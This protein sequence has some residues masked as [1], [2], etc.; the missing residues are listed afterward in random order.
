MISF[1]SQE[2]NRAYH[3]ILKLQERRP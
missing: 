2:V 3:S 1:E